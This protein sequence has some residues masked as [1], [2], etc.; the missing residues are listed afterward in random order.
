LYIVAR[1]GAPWPRNTY[2]EEDADGMLQAVRTYDR[3]GRL[4][5]GGYEG[6][7]VPLLS[8]RQ[9]VIRI[10]KG[11]VDEYVRSARA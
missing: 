9:Y 8:V 2:V 5:L 10:Q 4:G 11:G 6:F 1:D 3:G 7:V